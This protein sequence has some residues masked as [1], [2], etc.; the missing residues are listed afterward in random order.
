[1]FS[2]I[3]SIDS[4]E[5]FEKAS[6]YGQLIYS[7][8]FFSLLFYPNRLSIFVNYPPTKW[9]I[10]D[11]SFLLAKT[12]KNQIKFTHT[13]HRFVLMWWLSHAIG[14]T[15]TRFS[16]LCIHFGT[17]TNIFSIHR[18]QSSNNKILRRSVGAR[19]KQR[20]KMKVWRNDWSHHGQ[21]L[22]RV[23]R[24]DMAAHTKQINSAWKLVEEDSTLSRH[25]ALTTIALKCIKET[26]RLH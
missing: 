13:M 23:D 17:S 15:N 20:G 25:F 22:Q 2:F 18:R 19:K 10:M 12:N 8:H 1:M 5:S 16:R 26:L 24:T 21:V 6:L 7:W 3:I 14:M 4:S 9:F 11:C